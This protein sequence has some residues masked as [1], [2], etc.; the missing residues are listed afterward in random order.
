MSKP[1]RHRQVLRGI[2]A[3]HAC[4]YSQ[5]NLGGSDASGSGNNGTHLKVEP[6]SAWRFGLVAQRARCGCGTFNSMAG[7]PLMSV[8][9]PM[10]FDHNFRSVSSNGMMRSTAPLEARTQISP[11]RKHARVRAYSIAC[12]LTQDRSE[13]RPP[14][15]SRSV[16]TDITLERSEQMPKYL[17][18]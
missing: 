14:V 9:R 18:R 6:G 7:R 8:A 17:D 16:G 2:C 10:Y 11:A 12:L 1:I 15:S 13:L 4:H 5:T 3:R